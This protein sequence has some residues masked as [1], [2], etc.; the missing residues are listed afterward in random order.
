MVHIVFQTEK[1]K[2]K[3]TNRKRVTAPTTMYE[4]QYNSSLFL[5]PKIN[6][7]IT[8]NVKSIEFITFYK[9]TWWNNESIQAWKIIT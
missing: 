9:F 8:Q 7:N 4:N 3:T 5:E 2:K 6:I 1:Q